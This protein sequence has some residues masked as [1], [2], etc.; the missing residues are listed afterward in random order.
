MSFA[1]TKSSKTAPQLRA[2]EST[3]VDDLKCAGDKAALDTLVRAMERQFGKCSSQWD[4]FIH[5]GIHHKRH[6][7]GSITLDQ[8]HY[9]HQIQP[10]KPP[11]SASKSSEPLKESY[12]AEFHSVVGALGWLCNVRTDIMIKVSELQSKLGKANKDDIVK[13][14]QLIKWLRRKELAVKF[15]PLKLPYRI[16]CIN[17]ASFNTDAK[18]RSIRGTIVFLSTDDPKNI[19]GASY[20]LQ[21]H[22]TGMSQH[23]CC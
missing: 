12:Q 19:G 10:I 22:K 13:V 23:I 14:N 15:V 8:N 21:N 11:T 9:V 20:V 4:D 16:L 1:V 5:C 2:I 3:H 18:G 6:A 17:D 7:D